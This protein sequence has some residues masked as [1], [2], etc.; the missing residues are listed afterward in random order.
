MKFRKEKLLEEALN[1][2]FRYEFVKEFLEKKNVC[3]LTYED[4]KNVGSELIQETK[5]AERERFIGMLN[6]LKEYPELCQE[7]CKEFK[8]ELENKE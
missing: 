3:E 7:K 6:Y 5:K 8:K 2:T 4:Y 1:K